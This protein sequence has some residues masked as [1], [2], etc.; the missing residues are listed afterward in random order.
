MKRP[1]QEK[2]EEAFGSASW[3]RRSLKNVVNKG[4]DGG[5]SLSNATCS[6]G[7]SLSQW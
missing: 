6:T 1:W 3:R 7:F 2:T 4:T 5:L